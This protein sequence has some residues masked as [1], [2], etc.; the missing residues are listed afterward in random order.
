MRIDVDIEIFKIILI[1]MMIGL[2]LG[3]LLV[4][5]GVKNVVVI[6]FTIVL[7]NV[8]ILLIVPIIHLLLYI[9]KEYI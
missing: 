3:Y 8:Y 7:I 6:K 2:I 5:N 9:L 1:I 4:F